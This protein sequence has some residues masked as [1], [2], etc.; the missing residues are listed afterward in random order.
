MAKGKGRNRPAKNQQTTGS[1]LLENPEALAE[2]ISKTEKF[3]NENKTLVTIVFAVVVIIVG[4]IIG[5]RFYNQNLND[6]A[7]S[8]MFQAVFYYEQDSL[9]LALRGDGNNLGF[10]KIAEDYGSSKAGNIA[11]FYAGS[12]YMKQG[13]FD[14]A[15]LY[16]EDFSSDDLLVQARAY[17][18]LG[19]LYMEEENVTQAVSYYEQACNYKPNKEFT[20]VY[21]MKAAIAYEKLD[22]IESAK[23]A[24]KRIIDEFW[25]S[26]EF[27]AARKHYARLGGIES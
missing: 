22:D 3:F 18:L 7:Q 8:E 17:S 4:G 10:V 26:T 23:K 9:E 20:P 24:Y 11:N 21:L 25:D 15:R 5:L 27:E 12:I 19:D 2:Q 6:E 1:D 13:K 14:L 16:L